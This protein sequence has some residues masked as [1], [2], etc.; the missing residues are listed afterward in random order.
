MPRVVS[1]VLCGA[2]VIVPNAYLL[3]VAPSLRAKSQL[4]QSTKPPF[5]RPVCS[6]RK[7]DLHAC[8]LL[9][10]LLP[11]SHQARVEQNL[12]RVEELRAEAVRG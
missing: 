7:A 2:G 5:I 9:T 11:P 12:G 10:A 3:E 6:V 8:R 4:F 1:R